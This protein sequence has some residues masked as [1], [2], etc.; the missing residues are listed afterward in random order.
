MGTRGRMGS[1]GTLACRQ[2]PRLLPRAL[3]TAQIGAFT[4]GQGLGPNMPVSFWVP[5]VNTCLA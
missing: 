5:M 3:T 2:L 1:S 4:A